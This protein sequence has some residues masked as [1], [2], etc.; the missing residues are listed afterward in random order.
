MKIFPAIDIKAEFFY[1]KNYTACVGKENIF[2]TQFHPE[3]SQDS[4]LKILGNFLKI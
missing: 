4:G 2:G 3:K 1:G